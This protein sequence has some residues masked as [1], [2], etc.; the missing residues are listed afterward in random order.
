MGK[1]FSGG[2]KKRESIQTAEL[3][4]EGRPQP[5]AVSSENLDQLSRNKGVY[6]GDSSQQRERLPRSTS[7][8]N[9]RTQLRL[10]SP[11]AQLND[12]MTTTVSTNDA[13]GG[14]RVSRWFRK[15]LRRAKSPGRKSKKAE[16]VFCGGS[17]LDV[18]CLSTKS[19][20][21]TRTIIEPA[22]SSDAYQRRDLKVP[23]S[24]AT[25]LHNPRQSRS[26]H[27]TTAN[28]PDKVPGLQSNLHHQ[29]TN[30]DTHQ[31]PQPTV[32]HNNGQQS[33]TENNFVHNKNIRNKPD[34]MVNGHIGGAPIA[35]VDD[36]EV[37]NVWLLRQNP[38]Q[39][40]GYRPSQPQYPISQTNIGQNVNHVSPVLPK[41]PSID[42][43][44]IANLQNSELNKPKA[45]PKVLL[46]MGPYSSTPKDHDSFLNDTLSMLSNELSLEYCG[47][48]I[49][50]TNT[51]GS[52]AESVITS[53]YTESEI[54]PHALVGARRINN[55]AQISEH[56]L[57]QTNLMK[58]FYNK[59]N[60]AP[61]GLPDKLSIARSVHHSAENG[62]NASFKATDPE[63]IPLKEQV[64]LFEETVNNLP[65]RSATPQSVG[66]T[67]KDVFNF[68]N[69]YKN[70][71]KQQQLQNGPQ[72]NR[73]MSQ[74][75]LDMYS[76]RDYAET[77]SS[78]SDILIQLKKKALSHKKIRRQSASSQ[79]SKPCSLPPRLRSLSPTSGEKVSLKSD[80]TESK[81]KS[82]TKKKEC[83][84][85]AG[86]RK[87]KSYHSL[88]KAKDFSDLESYNPEDDLRKVLEISRSYGTLPRSRKLSKD[89]DSVSSL[90]NRN[91]KL[92]CPIHDMPNDDEVS[93]QT[94]RS[95]ENLIEEETD[96]K[97]S[98]SRS[99]SESSLSYLST[100]SSED[101]MAEDDET[102]TEDKPPQKNKLTYKQ[103]AKSHSSI[104][105]ASSQA[106]SIFQ[107]PS[108]G[109]EEGEKGKKD[110]MKKWWSTMGDIP[111]AVEGQCLPESQPNKQYNTMD[112]KWFSIYFNC[113]ISS[114]QLLQQ[115]TLIYPKVHKI[116]L[117]SVPS[118]GCK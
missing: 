65:L 67:T 48:S 21:V 97:K 104:S 23:S 37:G 74:P 115:I 27:N 63:L 39:F 18:G 34:S 49:T 8:P 113:I 99:S 110:M 86:V 85:R 43:P 112:S 62:L 4:H 101:E 52:A 72:M 88:S 54:T 108:V 40:P 93:K 9:I 69:S 7:Q 91:T 32:K 30:G 38:S 5:L 33:S 90:P 55:M 41:V 61:N 92:K 79:G 105:K 100:S 109:E 118:I 60:I 94:Q 103:R 102:F 28:L 78:E 12:I 56:K 13:E 24:N 22:L 19:A 107:P 36:G 106:T 16:E 26:P 70:E 3:R 46:K 50:P 95:K 117:I 84:H 71:L 6:I 83:S 66:M 68:Y 76:F 11:E 47:S 51:V 31:P 25:Q 81:R 98:L 44:D 111:G 10:P 17:T 42:C 45:G 116:T 82:H 58:N 73:Y 53:S 77:D 2:K 64:A 29:Q 14:N 114:V 96:T 57:L 35:G 80:Q 15:S 87:S 20:K 59:T 89:R 75:V 1:L